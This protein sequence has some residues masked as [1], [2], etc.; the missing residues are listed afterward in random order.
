MSTSKGRRLQDT[1]D[2]K[3]NVPK[4]LKDILQQEFQN[5]FQQWQAV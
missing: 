4:A 1:E 3:K 2:I 5:R